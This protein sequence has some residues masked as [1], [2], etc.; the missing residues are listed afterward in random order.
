MKFIGKVICF[1]LV[2]VG[3]SACSDSSQ[4]ADPDFTP[5]N[6]RNSFWK[7]K[8]PIVF[9]DEA[10]NNLHTKNDRFEPFA[11]VLTSDGYT[12]KRSKEKFTL[13]YLQQA[14]ILVIANALE[15]NRTDYTPPFDD[16]FSLE[17]V[18]AVKQWVSQGG[19]LFFIADHTPYPKISEKLWTAF[20]FEFIN[21]HVYYATFRTDNN[22]LVAHSITQGNTDS[23]RITQVKSMGG[24]AFKIPH[25][26]KPLLMLG[27]NAIAD[28]PVLPFQVNAKT[29]KISMDGWYQGAVLEVGK[30]RIAVFA[31]TAM[32]TSQVD[33]TTG[34][35][36][37]FV[38][39][40]AEEN[41]QFL[42]RIPSNRR[43]YNTA[44]L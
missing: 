16:A 21:G 6:T 41:E 18:A 42:L 4:Q 10:H 13:D 11:Q 14:D 31:E 7:I 15:Q 36:L 23:E 27:K 34:R 44:F 26:A 40:G 5:K 9:V 19:A 8:S 29:P 39:N 25:N 37:G 28:V 30:G 3:L 12:V 17:E 1:S 22:S 24:A 43:D 38:S 20:G 35:K 32:F 33:L 2:L